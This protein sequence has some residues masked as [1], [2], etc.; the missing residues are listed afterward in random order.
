MADWKQ[1]TARIRRARSGKDPLAQLANLYQKTSDA[2]VAFELAKVFESSGQNSDAAKWYSTAAAKFRRADWKNKA[3]EAAVRLGGGPMEAVAGESVQADGEFSLVSPESSHEDKES[4]LEKNPE[5]L[6]SAVAVT[7]E[8]QE[9]TKRDASIPSG[10]GK[11]RR[12]RGRRGG[13][14]RRRSP[15][16]G[17]TGSPP[18]S[19][20][21]RAGDRTE[22]PHPV[23]ETEAPDESMAARAMQSR[24]VPSL[25]AEPLGEIGPSPKGRYGDPGLSSRISLLEMQFRRLLA[26]PPAKLNEADRAPAGPGVFVLTDSDLTTYYYVET[27]QTLRIAVG[28]LIRGGNRRGADPIKP[29][30]AEHLG[31][32]ETRVAKYLADHC[33]V[34]WLQLDEGAS[35]FAHFVIAV[36]RPILNE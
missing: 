7:S 9:A 20:S 17:E 25:P 10:N 26:C 34:R 31:I 18:S 16:A 35:Q 2:M 36:L 19:R 8:I 4:P 30:L 3:Q 11:G 1:I 15:A 6:E 12:R 28:N 32:P 14:N 21:A 23:I 13:K 24:A 29:R 5:A 22:S 33:V 27:C